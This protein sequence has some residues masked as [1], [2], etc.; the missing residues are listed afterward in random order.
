MR[1]RSCDTRCI[2][3]DDAMGDKG[4]KKNKDKS[5]KQKAEQQK[6]EL[7]NKQEKNQPKSS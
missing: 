1:G 7:K 6:Q 4:G 5:K 3:K 2:G